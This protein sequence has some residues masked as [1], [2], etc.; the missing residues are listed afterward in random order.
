M[1]QRCG[2]GRTIRHGSASVIHSRDFIHRSGQGKLIS[3]TPASTTPAATARRAQ[4]SDQPVFRDP[5][6]IQLELFMHPSAEEL[7]GVLS[8]ADSAEAQQALRQV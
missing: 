4:G 3:T 5:D 2:R 1:A 8:D 7:T 6:N